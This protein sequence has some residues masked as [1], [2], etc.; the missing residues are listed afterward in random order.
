MAWSNQERLHGNSLEPWWL[1]FHAFTAEG[2]GSIPGEVTE[3]SSRAAWPKRKRKGFMTKVRWELKCSDT[4]V[5]S[6][7]GRHGPSVPGH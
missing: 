3:I 5:L 2:T 4:P 6:Q 7:S 1:G